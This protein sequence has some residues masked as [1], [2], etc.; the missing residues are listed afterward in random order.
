[1]K[2]I[3][4]FTA[5]I[6]TA[7]GHAQEADPIRGNLIGRIYISADTWPY[8]EEWLEGSD[9]AGPGSRRGP[10]TDR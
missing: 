8:F 3:V 7:L 2:R 10:R 9:L 6:F 4:V 1:M 5:L